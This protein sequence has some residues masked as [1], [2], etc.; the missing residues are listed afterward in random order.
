MGAAWGPPRR[1]CSV[2]RT[3]RLP[4]ALVTAVVVAEAAVGLLRPRDRGPEPVSVQPRAYF[5]EAELERGD[6]FR[7][8]QRWL[9]VAG[10]VVDLGLLVV[11]VRRPPR[12][13]GRRF[14][15]PVAAGA[16]AAAALSVGLAV[17]SLPIDAVARQR[18]RDVGLV[19]QSWGGYAWDWVRSQGIGAAL[20][21]A[22][23]ALLLVGMRRFGPHWWLPGAVIVVGF[24]AVMTYAGPVVLDPIF[25]RF[26]PLAAGELR[27]DVLAL[28]KR[29]GVDVGQVYEID[30][31]RRTTGAN[32]YVAGLGTTKRVVIYD[33]LIEDFTPAE[34]RLVVAHELGHVRYD[35][36]PKGLLW[37]AIVA[38]FGMFAAAQLTRR[39]APEAREG[40]PA[41]LPAVALSLALLVPAITFVSNQLSRD[42]E[43]RADAYSIELTNEPRTLIDFQRR[44]AVQNVSDVTPP[45]WWQFMVG[46]HPTTLE[47]IGLGEAFERQLAR[48]ASVS[49]ARQD[50]GEADPG[51]RP[52]GG[53]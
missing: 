42:V 36:V 34:T 31:S 24:G 52:P 6:A 13:L 53:S 1:V 8:G 41:V 35:D 29:A 10:V 47:R 50:P 25:N 21:G 15:H 44:I 17:A 22:G 30:A 27:S 18:A 43:R 26:T 19:T 16:A 23:G 3:L 7:R 37:V 45:A 33:N 39:L 49:R 46:T 51:G 11:L 28:A 32:A 48:G 12:A 2:R 20:A 9:F 38:P 14:G 5:S 4:I 40:T